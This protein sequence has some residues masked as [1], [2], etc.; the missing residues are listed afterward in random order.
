MS[1]SAKIARVETFPV[2][3]PTRGRFKFF[4]DIHG[5]P[6]GRQTVLVKITTDGGLVG[7]GQSVPVPTWSYE[8]LETAL[9]TLNQHLAPALIGRDVSD[10]G[11][12]HAVMNRVIASSFSIGQP[13]CKAGIDLALHDLVGKLQGK[14][15]AQ[16]WNRRG[17]ARI[18]VGYTLNPASVG[19]LEASVQAG[20]KAGY[21]H[22]NIKVAPNP[23]V[24]LEMCRRL[25]QLVP[26]SFLWADAN[27]GY[28]ESTALEVA[29]KLAE[30]GVAVLEQP[31][32]ANRLGG[33]RRLKKL[34]AIP[35]IMDEGVVS[36]VELEEFIRL[37]LLD[38]VAIKP[39][40]SGGLWEARRQIELAMAE[41]LLVLGSGLTD[42]D[43]SLAASL[44]LFGAYQLAKPA[45]LNGCQFLAASV[46]KQP[47]APCNG[48]L[49][50]PQG[51]GLGVE[52][53]EELLPEGPH[54]ML[55]AAA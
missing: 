17:L 35:I 43:I 25:K 52:V 31:L 5:R 23:A 1:A 22:F 55:E 37:E 15:L 54:F 41:G 4:E 51:P 27:G 2:V 16:L 8:T 7:W 40:R 11:G 3:Y 38:G 32:P 39:P 30:A 19:D 45:A 46:L 33:Y 42:P 12:I 6:L 28:D 29:P 13:I 10:I 9:S 14:S 49:E 24:D 47:F 36:A 34:G 18:E 48:F 53:D 26:D 44:G 50:V 20:L 21:R